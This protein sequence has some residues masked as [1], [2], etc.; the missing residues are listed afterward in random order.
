M[1]QYIKNIHKCFEKFL[2]VFNKVQKT[3]FEY[4]FAALEL[5]YGASSTYT[6]EKSSDELAFMF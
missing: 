4:Y 3:Y 2:K 6:T 1:K 5:N